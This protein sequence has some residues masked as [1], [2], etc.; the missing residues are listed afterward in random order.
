M[1]SLE[2]INRRGA[3]E[4]YAAGDEVIVYL[5]D[6]LRGPDGATLPGTL[7]SKEAPAD[8]DPLGPLPDAPSPGNLPAIAPP[9]PAFIP[10][11]GQNL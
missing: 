4:P 9:L 3:V 11:H 5:P 8:P 6:G 2:R 1:A 10:R 7:D